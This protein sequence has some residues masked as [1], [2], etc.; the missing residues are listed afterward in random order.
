VY[1]LAQDSRGTVWAGTGSGVWRFDGSKWQKLGFEWGAPSVFTILRIDRTDTVWIITGLSNDRKLLY[2]LPGSK[3]FQV[4]IPKTNVYGFTL[5]ADEKVLT[6]SIGPQQAPSQKHIPH[7]ELHVY[8]IFGTSYAQIVDRTN[9]VWTC[10][11]SGQLTR[12]AVAPWVNSAVT[13][14]DTRS[15]ETYDVYPGTMRATLVDRE[16]NIWFADRD[17]LYRFFYAP[18]FKEELPV[19]KNA[20][21]AADD[22]GAVWIAFWSNRTSN[23]LYR[24]TRGRIETF[25]IREMTD[26]GAAYRASDKT[27]WFGGRAG[28]WHLCRGKLIQVALP[29]GMAEYAFYLQAITEDR[30]GGLWVSFGRYGLFRLANGTWTSFVQSKDLSKGGPLVEFTDSRGRVWFGYSSFKKD[31]VA[32]L[33]GDKVHLFGKADGAPA[34][35]VTAISGRRTGVWVGGEFGLEKF[36]GKRFQVIHAVDDD[37]LLG[38]SGI[39]ETANGDLWLNGIS[40]IFHISQTEIAKALKDPSY[41]VRGQHLGGREGLP[42]AAEQIR[43]LPTAIEG[44]DGRLWFSETSGVVSLDPKQAQRKA[45]VP[46][47]AIQSVSADDK[48][49]EVNSPLNFPARTTSVEIGYS[50][51]SLSD[52][53]AVRSRVRLHETDTDWHEVTTAGPVEYRNLRPGH[54][55]FSVEA[56]DTDGVWSGDV[57]NLE[58]TIL[59][60]WYQTYWFY[61]FCAVAFLALLG[62]VYQL[63]LYQMRLQFAAGLEQRVN[64]RT[65]I[66]RDLHD[67]LLQS[68]NALLLRLQT[69][70]NVLPSQPE[71]A[72]QRINRA[73][74]QA[75]SAIT[76]G[77]DTLNELRSSGSAA[78]D[79]DQALS[80]FANELLSGA[81]SEPVPEINVQVEGTPV[82]LNPIVRDEVYRI[83]TE[84]VRNAIRHASARRIDVEIRYDEQQLRL[85]IGDN[86]IGIDPD[87]LNQDHRAGHWGLRGMRERARLVGGTLEV[88]S[89]LNVGTEIDLSI[90]A[91]SVY[92]TPSSV[93][94]SVLSRFRRS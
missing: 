75:S 34:G 68:F 1:T 60:A 26:W 56:S 43:P 45:T 18:F 85:R 52:P 14:P 84:A 74:E 11:E 21:M 92:A 13:Q 17:G 86:G 50:A 54:Y 41:P 37:W 77:R 94:K 82:P 63:R 69:V 20:A 9:A 64:E 44:S 5:D 73:I 46:P 23:K 57:A 83:A 53:E 12:F 89:Q 65:R 88:W 38:I 36:D 76:E 48:N 19:K 8:P 70:S 62:A 4:A 58:F 47:I 24:V 80:N 7:D 30:S 2:L 27:F 59:P 33:D 32:L 66:A 67:T 87:I 90:P 91:A 6:S 42:G 81:P 51:I 72:K 29:E 39:V 28:L 35:N 61:I 55:H 79:L 3:R 40:G 78:I 93:R 10:S 15:S 31:R 25:G 22:D 16:G 49:Y 71:E